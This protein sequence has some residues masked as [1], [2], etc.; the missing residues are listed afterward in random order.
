ME[1][2]RSV[3]FQSPLQ[4]RPSRVS[5]APFHGNT[6]KQAAN[7]PSCPIKSRL[8]CLS[9]PDVILE[10]FASVVPSALGIASG[11]SGLE[12]SASNAASLYLRDQQ[13]SF[14]SWFRGAW[15]Y[16]QG[17]HGGIFVLVI[18]AEILDSPF[19]DG[20][21]KDLSLL[22][23]LGIKLI[24][25]PGTHIQI[26]RLLIE[27]GQKPNY[28]GSY[29]ITDNAALEASME[30]AGKFRLDIEAKLSCQPP[31]P[32]VRRHGNNERWRVGV[33]VASG[34]FIAAKRRGVV[35]GVD[36]GATG[37]VKRLDVARIR[38]RLEDNCI[39]IISNLGYSSSGEVLNCNSYE[40]ATACAKELQADKLIS[41]LD[42][43]LLD[44][45]GRLIRFMTLQ[46]A[47][48]LIRKWA[49]ESETAAKY[50]KAVAG[51]DYAKSLGLLGISNGKAAHMNGVASHAIQENKYLGKV[52]ENVTHGLAV[53]GEDRLAR[54]HRYLSELIAAVFVCRGGVQRVHLLDA[55]IEGVLLL[56]LYSRDG[57][58]TMIA[59]DRYEGTR[60]AE[61]SDLPKIEGLL[62]PLEESG[63]LVKRSCEQLLEELESFTVVERDACIIA[64]AAL[65]PFYEEKCAEI[66]ALAVAP[67]CRGNGQGDKLLDYMENKAIRMGLK[68][69][70]LLTTRTAD[71]FIRR[72]FVQCTMDRIPK[73]RTVKIDL[74]WGSKYYVKELEISRHH[75]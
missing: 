41:L 23:G 30:V 1:L 28:S 60:A 56:E 72:G 21:C 45:N 66:A 42:G 38:K 53:G 34:N 18:S 67:E 69:L 51:N 4:V 48:E 7:L 63:V 70:F 15:P 44:D 47:D 12:E 33:G 37:E 71:W 11:A 61:V 29:R 75:N 58:G 31:I 26:D 40:V 32:V 6:H 52:D 25:I 74:T 54:D 65:F 46:D 16:I 50:V 36:Y 35:D 55:T 17:H 2:S 14:V 24:I 10:R 68:R 62:R 43:P 8:K 57:I 73:K 19:V 13:T 39:V 49:G 20:I 9:W 64:C 5:V 22:H 59:S 3:F 27:R